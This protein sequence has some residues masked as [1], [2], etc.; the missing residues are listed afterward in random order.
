MCT[1]TRSKQDEDLM[2]A[3]EFLLITRQRIG[4]RCSEL[5]ENPGTFSR[6]YVV[7]MD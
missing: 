4:F 6:Q 5:H 3:N 7:G 1:R 2:E